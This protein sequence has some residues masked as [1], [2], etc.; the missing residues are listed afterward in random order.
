MRKWSGKGR[1]PPEQ[2]R[3]RQIM[4]KEE[5]AARRHRQELRAIRDKLDLY[6]EEA[7]TVAEKAMVSKHHDFFYPERG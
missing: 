7:L 1:Y 5:E 6:G 2:E 3:E 4:L